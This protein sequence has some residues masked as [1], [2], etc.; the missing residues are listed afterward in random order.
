VRV[1][2]LAAGEDPLR[3]V[4]E[5]S[6]NERRGALLRALDDVVECGVLRNIEKQETNVC[7]VDG[8]EG[9]CSL[10]NTFWLIRGVGQARG[11]LDQDPAQSFG[12]GL[13][14]VGDDKIYRGTLRRGHRDLAECAGGLVGTTLGPRSA[15]C[16][17]PLENLFGSRLTRRCLA[18]RTAGAFF[19]GNAHGG[20]VVLRAWWPCPVWIGGWMSMGA[21]LQRDAINTI[22]L[23]VRCKETVAPAS[24]GAALSASEDRL[25]LGRCLREI[26]RVQLT[27]MKRV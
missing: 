16:A 20:L 9:F 8:R 10:E 2:D 11:F 12:N 21:A 3:F 19:L 17:D 24:I 4:G 25:A 23:M 14:R 6:S 15:V 1:W 13:T 22:P 27:G 26:I 5:Q 7:R 18:R